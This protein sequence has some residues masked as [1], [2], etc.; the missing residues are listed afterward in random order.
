MFTDPIR[1]DKK[2]NAYILEPSEFS[3][4]EIFQ[5]NRFI[6][7]LA[8]KSQLTFFFKSSIIVLITGDLELAFLPR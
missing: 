7:D 5:F 8:L 6:S 4:D 2:L 3:P 1:L